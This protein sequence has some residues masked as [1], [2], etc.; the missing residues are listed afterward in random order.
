ML[1]FFA[2]FAVGLAALNVAVAAE[3]PNILW[4]TSE[5]HGPEMGCYGDANARTPNVDA[6]AAKGM[7]FTR[8]W[9][10]AP[11]CA[12]AR[13]AIISGLYPSSSGGGHDCLLLRRSRQR[14]AAQQ[15]LAVRLWLERSAGCLLSGKMEAMSLCWDG[16]ADG[17]PRA[18]S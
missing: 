10:T 8:V 4:L 13:T 12:P 9:S 11:V 15:T 17:C 3:K 5:D 2:N 18:C 1:T 16:R 7:L 6:L 14:H